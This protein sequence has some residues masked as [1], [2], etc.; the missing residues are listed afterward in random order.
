MHP[1]INKYKRDPERAFAALQLDRVSGLDLL[2]Y[3][4]VHS[5]SAISA[6]HDPIPGSLS[7]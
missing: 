5:H 4:S 1:L 2:P 3:V 7:R 6:Y